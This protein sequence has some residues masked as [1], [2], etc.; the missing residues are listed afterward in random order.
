[1][2][3]ALRDVMRWFAL[4][5]LPAGL[6]AAPPAGAIVGGDEADPGEWPWQVVLSLSGEPFCGGVLVGLDLVVTAAHCVLGGSDASGLSARAGSVELDSGGQ[7][8]RVAR[9]VRHEE[10]DP[11]NGRNDIAV[12]HLEAPFDPA[13]GVAAVAL[14]DAETADRLTGEGTPVVV[15]GFGATTETGDMAPKLREAEVEV[16]DDVACA[17]DYAGAG[18]SVFAGSQMC[19][20]FDTGRID[21][22]FGDSGGPLVAPLGEDRAAWYLVGIVS[23]GEGCGLA[24]RPTVYTEVA[25]FVDWLDAQGA[26]HDTGTRV[27]GAGPLRLPAAG[28]RGKASRYPATV[29]VAG[30]PG[31]IGRVAVELR[32]LSHERPADLD[33]WLRAPNGTIVTLV[34]DVGGREPLDDVDVVIGAGAAPGADGRFGLRVGPTDR[35]EDLQRRGDPPPPDLGALAGIDPNGEWQLLVADDRTGAAGRLEGW[36]LVLTPAG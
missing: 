35:E 18:G 14:P 12:L 30:V 15:T 24:R 17:G 22:C 36:T 6:A 10:Y 34:S 5:L 7:E 31:P 32:G 11:V 3:R 33:L 1:M 13:P 27:D 23:W 8:R 9:A 4:L 19:A 16:L 28:T 2:V 26:V 20:G 29:A 25:A 21:A